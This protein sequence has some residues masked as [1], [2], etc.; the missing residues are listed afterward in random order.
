MAERQVVHFFIKEKIARQV[1][2]QTA[3]K[4]QEGEKEEEGRI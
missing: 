3:E 1:K 4:E 2:V